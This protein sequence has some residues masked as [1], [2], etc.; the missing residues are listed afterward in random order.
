MTRTRQFWRTHIE[1][2]APRHGLDPDLVEAIVEQESDGLPHATRF[3]PDFWQRYMATKP[4][5]DGCQ[6][7]RFA[8]SIG[9]MQLMPTTAMEHGYPL[10]NEGPEGLFSPLVNLEY[11]CRVLAA[12]LVW[13]KGDVHQA[14]AG[15]NGG[16]GG[17]AKARP[18]RYADSVLAKFERI[19]SGR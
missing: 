8:S 15:Y 12:L 10:K 19:R 1:T 14:A 11:G 7:E 17:Y 5:W 4:E 13:A 9:L 6:P 2:I 16:R 3:E 18:Q